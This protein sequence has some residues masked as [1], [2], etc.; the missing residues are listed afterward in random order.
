MA[1][2]WPAN[3]GWAVVRILVNLAAGQE[4][5]SPAASQ[6][7]AAFMFFK[8]ERTWLDSLIFEGVPLSDLAPPPMD[9][10]GFVDFV[11]VPIDV[12]TRA[13]PTDHGCVWRAGL[14]Q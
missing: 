13:I 12:I 14:F 9:Y 7:I 5:P 11:P 3:E 10:I 1:R 4:V 6:I 2:F 8:N